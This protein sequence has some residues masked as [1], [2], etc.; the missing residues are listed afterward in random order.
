[1]IADHHC[2][3]GIPSHVD[4]KR[5]WIV[6]GLTRASRICWGCLRGETGKVRTHDARVGK[7][8]RCREG[9]LGVAAVSGIDALKQQGVR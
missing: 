7:R 6:T 9:V 3:V 2:L 5:G 4:A 1:M 8:R